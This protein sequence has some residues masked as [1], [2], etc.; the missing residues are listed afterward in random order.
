LN[1][2][3][4]NVLGKHLK[5]AEPVA[6][7]KAG[8]P[9]PNSVAAILSRRIAIQGASDSDSDSDDDDDEGWD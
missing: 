1:Y 2:C 3:E 7:E 5:K 6:Q 8:T 9:Q 4:I